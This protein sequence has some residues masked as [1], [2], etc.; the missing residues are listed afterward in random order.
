M[1]FKRYHSIENGHNVKYIDKIILSEL[2]KDN[3]MY[4]V[5]EKCHGSNMQTTSD[6]INIRHGKR[7][8]FI[9][10]DSNFRNFQSLKED[11]DKKT[12]LLFEKLK[13]EREIDEVRIYYEIAGDKVQTGIF[14]S[15]KQFL[16][17]FDIAIIKDEI[18]TFLDVDDFIE[19]CEEFNFFYAKEL[20]RGTLKECMKYTNKYNSHI[21]IWL[22]ENK[23][24][25][26]EVNICEG[27]VIKPVKNIY[28][29]DKRIIIKNKNENWTETIAKNKINWS[30][31]ITKLELSEEPKRLLNELL[32]LNSENRLK[33]VM[34][35]LE[36]FNFGKLLG[37]MNKDIFE[38]F[39]K[40]YSLKHLDVKDKKRINNFLNFKI[41]LLINKKK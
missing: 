2:A 13:N 23:N 9:A 21:P 38:E 41:S 14:Y 33:N 37:L 19:L 26:P 40:N 20:F 10:N 27:N 4:S 22:D 31:D 5:T 15:K 11:I 39:N 18:E 28:L 30:K 1:K 7:S 8:S 16:Y 25:I 29:N 24:D 6:G 17:I 34:S 35:K 12:S 32:L 36:T 3:I